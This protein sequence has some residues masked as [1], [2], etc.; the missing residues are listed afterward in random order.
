MPPHLSNH[1]R[2]RS[3]I[4]KWN[5][6]AEPI[7]ANEP[8]YQMRAPAWGT[9][10]FPHLKFSYAINIDTKYPYISWNIWKNKACANHN[11]FYRMVLD[12][13]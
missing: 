12:I 13:S 7:I 2:R 4:I 3:I 5:T 8:A 9:K 1:S 10:T 6:V 11:S